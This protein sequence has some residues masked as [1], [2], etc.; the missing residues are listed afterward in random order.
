MWDY[1]FKGA[2][3]GGGVDYS[4]DGGLIEEIRYV[5]VIGARPRAVHESPESSDGAR[6]LPKGIAHKLKFTFQKALSQRKK[7]PAQISSNWPWL[8]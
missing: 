5:P 7:L 8:G 3:T 1:F 4:R 6:S 2:K